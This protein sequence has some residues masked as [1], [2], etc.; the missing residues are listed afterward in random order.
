VHDIFGDTVLSL[1]TGLIFSI[2]YGQGIYGYLVIG[3]HCH[4]LTEISDIGYAAT[5]STEKKNDLI[6]FQQ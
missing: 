5:N 2:I 1:I 6:V 4:F 3:K